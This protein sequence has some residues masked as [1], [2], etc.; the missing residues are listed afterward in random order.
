M[1]SVASTL[2]FNLQLY[3]DLPFAGSYLKLYFEL[4]SFKVLE[5]AKLSDRVLHLLSYFFDLPAVQDRV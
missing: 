4:Y 5:A 3:V 2:F 1:A